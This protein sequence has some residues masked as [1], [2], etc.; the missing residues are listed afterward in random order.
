MAQNRRAY[1]NDPA[2]LFTL[3]IS[4]QSQGDG[5]IVIRAFEIFDHA[6]KSRDYVTVEVLQGRHVVFARG[7]LWV[8]S[9]ASGWP[10]GIDGRRVRDAVVGV[11]AMA[12]GDTDQEYFQ[13]Y[14][15]EQ[16]AWARHNGEWLALERERRFGV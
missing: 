15:P 13:G 7:Q 9:P 10:D 5:R 3:R 14:S 8:G 11:A 1:I 6:D 2:W 12:P 4:G 16:L